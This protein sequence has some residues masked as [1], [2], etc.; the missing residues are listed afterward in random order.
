MLGALV[1]AATNLHPGIA[2][3]DTIAKT[4]DAKHGLA[5][6]SARASARARCCPHEMLVATAAPAKVAPRGRAASTGI[7]GAVAPAR[8]RGAA[9]GRRI[10]E[11]FPI[12]DGS[13]RRAR[14]VGDVRD[15]AHAAGARRAR[16]AA[17]RRPNH[18]FIDAVYGNFPLM[19]ALI[20][21]ITF[22]LL[23]RAFRSLL[24]PAKA[25]MLNILSVGGRLGRDELVWQAGPR[26]RRDLGHRRDGLDHRVDPAHGLRVPVRALDGLRGVHPRPHAR[27][28]R[29]APATTDV[30]VVRGIGRTGRLVTSA[31]LILFLAFAVARLR[32]GDRRE[33]PGHRAGGRASSS[34]PRSSARCSSPRWCRC[35]GA[36]TGCCRPLPA[37][38]LRVEPSLPPRAATAERGAG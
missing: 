22:V 26:L 16:S 19:I 32:A 25:V 21:V 10:V 6:W 33:G 37:R 7:H 29:R 27:G 24:L 20:A 17:S 34:T 4:G 18:D 15:A 36:G 38:I 35:S 8:R 28:V 9:A 3:V 12:P 5:R 13:S 14:L 23:A 31:A 30:A 2:D 11:A 1:L